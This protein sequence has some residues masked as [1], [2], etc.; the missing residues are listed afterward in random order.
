MAFSPNINCLSQHHSESKQ[1]LIGNGHL[2][3]VVIDNTEEVEASEE[4]H[5]EKNLP[6]TPGSALGGSK[7]ILKHH[8][9]L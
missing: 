3:A 6:F 8:I 9:V 4:G 7:N 2:N 1:F 5:E